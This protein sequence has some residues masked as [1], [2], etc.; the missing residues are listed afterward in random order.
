[1]TTRFENILTVSDKRRQIKSCIPDEMLCPLLGQIMDEPVRLPSGKI[2]EKLAIILHL[3]SSPTD[4]FSRLPLTLE[5]CETDLCLK[6]YGL[7]I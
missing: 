3:Q 2:V 4:P 5:Q 1:M 6:N 7:C